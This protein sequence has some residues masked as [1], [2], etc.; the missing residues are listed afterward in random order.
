MIIWRQKGIEI[1]KY[2]EYSIQKT[3]KYMVVLEKYPCECIEELRAREGEWIRQMGT[4]NQK[5]AGRE[6]QGWYQDNKEECKVKMAEY[7]EQNRETIRQRE[8][9]YRDNNLEKVREQDRERYKQ[10]PEKRK[11]NVKQWVGKNQEY[12]RERAR[13]Y[14]ENHREELRGT[15][16]K[17]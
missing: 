11:E 16:R 7:R 15:K 5:V 4:L 14:R 8:K 3:K 1:H 6:I 13:I 2:I 10:N 17:K 12:V 9:E